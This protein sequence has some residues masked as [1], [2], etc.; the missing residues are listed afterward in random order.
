MLTLE[1]AHIKEKDG[2]VAEAADILN[3]VH[4]ETYGSMNKIEKVEYIL[5]Q[6]RLT[7]LKKDYVRAHI[8]SKKINRK[9]LVTAGFGAIKIK[10]YTMMIEYHVREGDM[11]ELF[12]CYN[13]MYNTPQVQADPVQWQH[14]LPYAVLF[15]LLSPYGPEQNNMLHTLAADPKLKEFEGGAWHALLQHYITQELAA[16]PLPQLDMAFKHPVFSGQTAVA[17]GAPTDA[18][19]QAVSDTMK[20]AVEDVE[21]A[22]ADDKSVFKKE[23][24]KDEEKKEEEEKKEKEQ[25]SG[26]TPDFE[27]APYTMPPYHYAGKAEGEEGWQ[28]LLH[29]RTVE[30]NLRVVSKCYTRIRIQHLASMLGLTTDEVEKHMANLVTKSIIYARIDRPAGIAVF[31]KPDNPEEKLNVFGADLSELLDLM[32]TTCHLV[33]KENMRYKIKA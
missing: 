22:D 19:K 33:H 13:Q 1:L 28:Q 21:M 23:K 9:W 29:T 8:V 26:D 18:Q 27:L 12:K 30:H 14:Y 6:V 16:W 10:F 11:M 25:Q 31:T 2:L 7:I 5:E 17:V 32:E 20:A 3:E 4:V 15:L 24:K